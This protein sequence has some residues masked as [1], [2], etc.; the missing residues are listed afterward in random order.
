M[1]DPVTTVLVVEDEDSFIDALTIG[2]AREGY[3]FGALLFFVCCFA[4][5]RLAA[6]LERRL[7]EVQAR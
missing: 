3:L 7:D 1:P 5:S 2:L 6:G 4:M